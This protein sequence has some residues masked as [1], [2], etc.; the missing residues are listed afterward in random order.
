MAH[1]LGFKDWEK[2]TGQ[3]LRKMGITNTMSNGN[4]N[5]E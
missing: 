3:G 4:K 5:I 2:C 1:E